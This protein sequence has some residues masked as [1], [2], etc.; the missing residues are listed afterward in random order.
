MAKIDA[1]SFRMFENLVIETDNTYTFNEE[2][3]VNAFGLLLEIVK[4]MGLNPMGTED[5]K[6][7]LMFLFNI[8]I[9]NIPE[10]AHGRFIF[11]PNHVS[12]MD[13]LI[14]GLLHPKIKMVSKNDWVDNE[15]LKQFLE[16]HYDLCGL[17]RTSLKSLRAL[18]KDSISY[19]N[20]SNENKHYLVFS[21]GTISDFNHNSLERISP[22]AQKISV[23]TDVPIVCVFVEQVSLYQPT[24]IIFDKPMKLSK[25]DDFREIWLER[26]TAMQETLVPPARLPIL[27]YKH[28]NNNKPG[29]PFFP[30]KYKKPPFQK[31]KQI[32]LQK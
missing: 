29:E 7:G 8:E 11:A 31:K 13:A 12:D 17:D 20:D 5:F 25:K 1:A 32:C 2:T 4:N 18:L 6:K 10:L 28:A 3:A 30:V 26:I 19:F 16:I 21:Q 9:L 27:S 23:K 24:R 15:K 22:I 14:L